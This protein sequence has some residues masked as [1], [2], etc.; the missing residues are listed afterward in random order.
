MRNG[1]LG[2]SKEQNNNVGGSL[3]IYS[4]MLSIVM[5]SKELS[6]SWTSLYK[7]SQKTTT[8]LNNNYHFQV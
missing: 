3:F 7:G 2:A 4:I 8:W 1:A 5:I 6:Y